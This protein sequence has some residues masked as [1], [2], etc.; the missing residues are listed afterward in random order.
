MFTSHNLSNVRFHVSHFIFFL[1]WLSWL[2]DGP[3]STGPTPSSF[4]FMWVLKWFTLSSFH[5]LS[6]HLPQRTQIQSTFA[7]SINFF[8]VKIYI[9]FFYIFFL[10]KVN[11]VIIKQHKEFF[12]LL[13]SMSF[14]LATLEGWNLSQSFSYLAFQSSIFLLFSL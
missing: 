4:F 11:S 7:I 8:K 13:F 3:L 6:C 5:V 12:S 9:F 14:T 10:C 2:V 1:N